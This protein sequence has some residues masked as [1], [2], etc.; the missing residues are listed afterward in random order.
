MDGAV[1][2]M[3]VILLTT[4]TFL[5]KGEE[6]KHGVACYHDSPF[7]TDTLSCQGNTVIQIANIEVAFTYQ[8]LQTEQ[9]CPWHYLGSTTAYYTYILSQCQ[10]KKRCLLNSTEVR[11]QKYKAQFHLCGYGN[12][13]DRNAVRVEYLCKGASLITPD[14]GYS[15][16]VTSAG[17]NI[18]IMLTHSS[19]DVTSDLVTDEFHTTQDVQ[20]PSSTLSGMQQISANDGDSVLPLTTI[21]GIVAGAVIVLALVCFAVVILVRRKGRKNNH[22][23]R[24]PSA[25]DF[26]YYCSTTGPQGST[27]QLQVPNNNKTLGSTCYSLAGATSELYYS[28]PAANSNADHV[29]E[30]ILESPPPVPTVPP[31]LAPPTNVYNECESCPPC[32]CCTENDSSSHTVKTIDNSLY[33]YVWKG[34]SALN[35]DNR[36]LI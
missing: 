2:L 12:I 9:L 3:L 7:R 15:P 25:A 31:P 24:P 16:G 1:L 23:P 18:T 36:N 30:E 26:T 20:F 35:T 17:E 33:N 14:R 27:S 5:V 11:D 21:L 34:A 6:S 29:Y 4:H 10:G 22:K 28:S 8:C 13:Q 32:P 19:T